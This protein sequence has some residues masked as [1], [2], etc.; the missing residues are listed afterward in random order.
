MKF[1]LVDGL[2]QEPQPRLRGKCPA[3]ASEMISKC[4]TVKVHH[5]AH[6]KGRSCDPWWENET[7]WHRDWKNRFPVEWQ[8]VSCKDENG[9]THIADVKRPDGFYIEF[10]YSPIPEEEVQSRNQFYKNLVWVINGNR[11]S[12]D[13]EKVSSLEDL[14]TKEGLIDITKLKLRVVRKWRNLSRH[15]F[16][17]FNDTDSSEERRIFY[18]LY[19]KTHQFFC[20]I[21]VDDFVSM[22]SMKGGLRP[23]ILQGH[24]LKG[25]ALKREEQNIR[26]RR[27]WEKKYVEPFR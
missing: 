16:I 11:S 15:V 19:E 21:L 7:P 25:E 12:L 17:D 5:W 22:A 27:E 2:R 9:V 10:Q 26:N 1:A 20:K 24:Q 3:C 6:K 23:F 13:R 18:L 8:E 14:T 4:G